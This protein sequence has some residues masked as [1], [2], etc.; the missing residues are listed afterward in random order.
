MPKVEIKPLSV[1]EAWQGRRY[2][3]PKYR[4]YILELT[5][6][7]KPLRIPEGPLAITMEFGLS[8]LLADFDN[9]VKPFVDVL[10][11][12]Y[13]FNDRRVFYAEVRK[14]LCKKGSEYIRFEITPYT[15]D[16]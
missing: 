9:P 14:R 13:G 6:K 10:Q 1:N 11:K 7:L 12:R 8:S 3:T 16:L 5:L 15:E 2:K 4:A